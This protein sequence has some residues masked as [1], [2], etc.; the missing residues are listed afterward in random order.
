MASSFAVMTGHAA[1]DD[2]L[3]HAQVSAD[4]I[5]LLMG[6]A[7]LRDASKRLIDAGRSA[8][9][10]AAIV[11]W[12][13]TSQQRVAVATLGS[14]AEVAEREGIGS[15][16]TTIVG[17]VVTLRD[18]V[19]WFEARPLFGRRVVVTR[20][21]A[22]ARSLVELL[23]DAGASVI[24][25]P[26]VEI[27][28]PDDA[29]ELQSAVREA[30]NERFDWIAFSSSNAVDSFFATLADLRI[31]VRTLHA[32]KMACVGATTAKGL[33]ARGV[34]ADLVPDESTAEGLAAALGTGDGSILLPRVEGG[35][36]L[37]PELLAGAGWAVTEVTAYKSVAPA[38]SR[39]STVVKEGGFDVV[40]FASASS[41]RNFVANVARPDEVGIGSDDDAGK[42]V[43]CIGPSTAAEAAA[44]GMRVDVTA[45]AQSTRGLLEAVMTATHR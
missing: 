45:R 10:P 30:V 21:R 2:D 38:P 17:K 22:Q 19:A 7:Q 26:T 29:T 31:D 44:L 1:E 16:A 5:V 13:T 37:L 11:Q 3:P 39:S 4:T 43:V 25:L 15:P 34:L 35:P 6:V 40:T 12:G 8:D 20:P 23:E 42:L 41:V 33:A 36:R 18:V 14:I 27:T 32:T 24:A 28:P 9:E